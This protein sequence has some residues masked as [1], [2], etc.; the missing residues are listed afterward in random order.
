MSWSWRIGPHDFD[1]IAALPLEAH[2]PLREALDALELDP[3]GASEPYG[4]D[5][6]VTREARFGAVGILAFW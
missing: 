6:G 2:G 4:V 3:Y 1:T 5:D